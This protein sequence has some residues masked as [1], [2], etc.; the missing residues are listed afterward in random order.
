MVKFEEVIIAEKIVVIL[1]ARIYITQYCRAVF[2]EE[3]ILI[4]V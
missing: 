1:P 4:L 3:Q 2:T